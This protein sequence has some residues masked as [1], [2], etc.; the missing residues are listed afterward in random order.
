MVTQRDLTIDETVVD[1]DPG[2]LGNFQPRSGNGSRAHLTLGCAPGVSAVT[3]GWDLVDLIR[4]EERNSSSV[5]TYVLP[6]DGGWLRNYGDGQWVLYPKKQWLLD[7]TFE[8]YETASSFRLTSPF[9]LVFVTSLIAIT[10]ASFMM[11]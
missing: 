2:I 7:S 10:L 3:T 8:G 11:R 5:K 4:L 1:Q 6:S 9:F